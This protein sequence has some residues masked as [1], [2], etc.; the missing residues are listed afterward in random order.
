MNLDLNWQ[1]PSA[2]K[3]ENQFISL[4]NPFTKSFNGQEILKNNILK[5]LS[6]NNQSNK[7]SNNQLLAGG[8]GILTNHLADTLTNNLF[9]DDS[10]VGRNLG[11]IFSSGISSTGNTIS[12]NLVKGYG[13]TEGLGKNV[14]ASLGGVASGIIGNYIGNGI[15]SLGGNSMLSRGL[16]ATTASAIGQIGGKGLQALTQGKNFFNMF[17]VGKNATNAAKAA[18]LAT[19]SNAINSGVKGA[20]ATEMA[21]KAAQAAS[22][23]SKFANWAN[24]GGLAGTAVG[25]GL[26]A[27]FG[28]SKEYGGKYGGITQTAD[29]AYDLIGAGVG[30]TG[31]VGAIVSGGMALNKGLSN[32]FGSTSGMTVQDA[33]LGSAFMP[34]PVKWINM[35]GA[36]TTGDFYRQSWQNSEKTKNFMGSSFGNLQSK[37]DR[38]RE[39]AG[40]TYG[41]FSKGAYREAQDNLNFANEAWGKILAM[42][43]QNLYQNIRSQDMSSINNQRYA[44]QILG[45]WNP[46]YRGKQGMKIFNNATNHNI[47]MRLLSGAAL[48]D[49]KQMIL[50]S[51]VD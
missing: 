11:A 14:G 10:E 15:N 27:A 32:I 37:F 7:F 22:K 39:E 43:D 28:P 51:A 1:Q 31:P 44:Q 49:N 33:I 30:F 20:E 34:A 9:G 48:I 45:G 25:M 24:I 3:Y 2:T 23:A 50:C 42:A 41:L 26:Q 4:S 17:Q 29:L 35:I 46:I 38:A 19:F 12:N 16:G 21:A 13:L 47:G 40:K 6:S 36:N 18:Q 8:T 5:N